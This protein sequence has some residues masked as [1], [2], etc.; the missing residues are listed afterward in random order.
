MSSSTISNNRDRMTEVCLIKHH[1]FR[2]QLISK[3]VYFVMC[4]QIFWHIFEL[5]YFLRLILRK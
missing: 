4:P 5:A 3:L 2:C 1:G